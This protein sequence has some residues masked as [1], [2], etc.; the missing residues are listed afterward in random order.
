MLQQG[1]VSP[2]YLRIY[3]GNTHQVVPSC[4]SDI[5][6]HLMVE[7]SITTHQIWILGFQ[8]NQPKAAGT[9]GTNKPNN[10][11]PIYHLSRSICFYSA[12]RYLPKLNI[13]LQ[14]LTGLTSKQSVNIRLTAIHV[15]ALFIL[16]KQALVWVEYR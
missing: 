8:A 7:R 11:N 13:Y 10:E 3:N 16:V 4:I 14:Y 1:M 9:M 6:R 5:S 2:I 12:K 15:I